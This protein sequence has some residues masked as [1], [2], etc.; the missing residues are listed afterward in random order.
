MKVEETPKLFINNSVKT[1]IFPRGLKVMELVA[2][3][4]SNIEIAEAMVVTLST[5]ENHLNH[6]YKEFGFPS[7]QRTNRVKLSNIYWKTIGVQALKD[8]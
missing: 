8:Q 1:L 6:L 5:V 2:Q 4:F 3:G 7:G